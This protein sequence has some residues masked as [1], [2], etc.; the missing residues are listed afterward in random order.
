MRIINYNEIIINLKE[1]KKGRT[2]K[3]SGV[4]GRYHSE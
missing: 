2:P 4:I 1:G 3:L